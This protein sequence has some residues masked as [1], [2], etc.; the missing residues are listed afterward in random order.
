LTTR[1]RRRTRATTRLSWR[2]RTR[3][4]TRF[5]RRERRLAGVPLCIDATASAA[6]AAATAAATI[7]C[8]RER[9]RASAICD[10]AATGAALQVGRRGRGRRRRWRPAAA[11][12]DW[13]A[14]LP[15][16]HCW[17]QSLAEREWLGEDMSAWRHR[18]EKVLSSDKYA[19]IVLC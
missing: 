19:T 17:Q 12:A 4:A 7:V 10:A 13:F 11:D 6:A 8:R 9:R 1:W 16:Y 15:L 2:R 3:A 14:N 5:R 18:S